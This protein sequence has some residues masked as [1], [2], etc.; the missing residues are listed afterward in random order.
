M[1]PSVISG[2]KISK[3]VFCRKVWSLWRMVSK[4]I[5]FTVNGQDEQVE[6]CS[7]DAAEDVKGEKT[8]LQLGFR[9]MVAVDDLRST[10]SLQLGLL[11]LKPKEWDG[12]SNPILVEK[13]SGYF[14]SCPSAEWSDPE[15]W[16]LLHKSVSVGI[17]VLVSLMHHLS[18]SSIPSVKFQILLNSDLFR[19]AAE[20]GKDDTLKLFN[21]RGNVV[22]ISPKLAENN[23]SSKYRLE[24]AVT[25]QPGRGVCQVWLLPLFWL[26]IN[27]RYSVRMKK[28]SFIH[29]LFF[30]VVYSFAFIFF[31]FW[32]NERVHYLH[33]SHFEWR[34]WGNR[35]ELFLP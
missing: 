27:Y 8:S 32:R 3:R 28:I 21:T 14:L 19:V 1:Q 29:H 12:D 6:F 15:T 23:S 33:L 26:N 34:S 7:D 9:L 11:F 22:S 35:T 13:G 4:V 20:A 25:M 24:V 18:A 30:V 2:K 17:T 10:N 5:Y 16:K 31:C